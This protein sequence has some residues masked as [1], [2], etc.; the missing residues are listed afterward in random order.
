M[1]LALGILPDSRVFVFASDA[2][3]F[4]GILQ[5]RFHEVWSLRLGSTLED[6]PFYTPTTT[7]ETFPFPAATA[8][9]RKAVARAAVELDHLRTSW[10]NPVGSAAAE[11]KNRTLTHLYNERPAWLANAHTA[12]DAAVAGAYGWPADIPEHEVLPRLLA[13]NGNRTPA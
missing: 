11:V 9:Q 7:F 12:L 3:E 10:L 4:F 8:E 13:L 1:W 5:S 6:R 2:D